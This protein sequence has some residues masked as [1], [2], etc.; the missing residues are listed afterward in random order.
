MRIGDYVFD[1][2]NKEVLPLL[3]GPTPG[4]VKSG[5]AAIMSI[6]FTAYALVFYLREKK[7]NPQR[8]E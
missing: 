2:R 7:K 5:L 1:D 6:L 4:I 8:T 3:F